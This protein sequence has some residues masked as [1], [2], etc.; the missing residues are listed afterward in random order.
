MSR[1]VG[2]DIQ[3][4]PLHPSSALQQPQEEKV[5]PSSTQPASASS[6]ENLATSLDQHSFVGREER[7]LFPSDP[8]FPAPSPEIIRP[9]DLLFD[10]IDKVRN[11]FKKYEGDDTL[12]PPVYWNTNA[13]VD[14]ERRYGRDLSVTSTHTPAGVGTTVTDTETRGTNVVNRTHDTGSPIPKED[15]PVTWTKPYSVTLAQWWGGGSSGKGYAARKDASFKGTLGTTSLQAVAFTETRTMAG[16]GGRISP[17]GIEG[18]GWARGQ[19]VAIGAKVK[20]EIKSNDVKLAGQNVNAVLGAQ[21]QPY[22]GAEV[23]VSGWVD[24]NVRQ[25]SARID[26]GGSAFVGA[27]GKAHVDFGLKD[28]QLLN[29]RVTG[30]V[31]AGVGADIGAHVGFSKGRFSLGAS[32]GIGL[33]VG[34]KVGFEID[35]DVVT[36]GK[37]VYHTLDR[38]GDGRLSLKDPATGIAQG[39]SLAAKGIEK[40]ADGLMHVLDGNQDGKFSPLDLQIRLKQTGQALADGAETV[41]RGI[42]RGAQAV[43]DGVEH[44][45]DRNGDGTVSSTD[46]G[47]GLQQTR[48]AVSSTGQGIAQ[49]GKKVGEVALAL[50]RG[51]LADLKDAG[52]AIKT[53]VQSAGQALHQ[54]ADIDGNGTLELRDLK[55]AGEK[56]GQGV[57][58]FTEAGVHA[59]QAGAHAIAEGSVAV[60]GAIA[61]GAKT[62]AQGISTG[63]EAGSHALHQAADRNGDG[64]ISAQDLVVGTQQAGQL[65]ADGVEAIADGVVAGATA[66]AR[67]IRQAGQ[68]VVSGT[69]SFATAAKNEIVD[70]GKII[71]TGAQ[72]AYHKAKETVHR[73]GTFLGL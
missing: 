32:A 37:M 65:V 14:E 30:E 57:V 38:D 68:A 33:G 50:A 42:R 27:K 5:N 51:T 56:L 63:I 11:A 12:S 31:W 49:A 52:S 15:N 59:V 53:G 9:S 54:A 72:E 26:V 69:K 71:A 40:T 22:L 67:G 13:P 28:G 43:A 60:A 21:V 47:V 1:R 44:L 58:A 73:V 41:G 6:V 66:T 70:A 55:V 36:A 18:G 20:A 2:R 7:N 29:G 48:D 23:G 46:L 45:L 61:Q 24:V 8:K 34:A 17:M 25:P 64:R 10:S 62:V 4:S 16:L 19:A 35:V 39:L 3:G